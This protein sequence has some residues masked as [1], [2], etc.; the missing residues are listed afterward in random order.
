MEYDW[1]LVSLARYI[2]A[3]LNHVLKIVDISMAPHFSPS[4]CLQLTI[5]LTNLSAA[6]CR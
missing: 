1:P 2:S 3:E 6:Q 4:L 5:L